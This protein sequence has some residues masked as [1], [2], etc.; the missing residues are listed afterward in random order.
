MIIIQLLKKQGVNHSALLTNVLLLLAVSFVFFA[1]G[2]LTSDVIFDPI[3]TT[4]QHIT[5]YSI[6]AG[7]G[8][9]PIDQYVTSVQLRN[10]LRNHVQQLNALTNTGFSSSDGTTTQTLSFSKFINGVETINSQFITDYVYSVADSFE[11]ILTL[12]KPTGTITPSD[13]FFEYEL[14]FNNGLTTLVDQDGVLTDLI[15]TT[16]SI[17]AQDYVIIAA[18]SAVSGTT[19]SISMDLL[20]PDLQETLSLGDTG[21]YLSNNKDYEVTITNVVLNP[22][23]KVTFGVSGGDFNDVTFTLNEGETTF[24]SNNVPFVLNTVES[25]STPPPST[26]SGLASTTPLGESHSLALEDGII[27]FVD[28]TNNAIRVLNSSAQMIYTL[29]GDPNSPPDY[30]DSTG[31]FALFNNPR[32]IVQSLAEPDLFYVADTGNHVIRQLNVSGS[33]HS[34]NPTAIVTTIA[35]T[36]TLGDSVGDGSTDMD[37]LTAAFNSPEDLYIQQ[38]SS[39]LIDSLYVFDN[40]NTKLKKV[41][42]QGGLNNGLWKVNPLPGRTADTSLDCGEDAPNHYIGNDHQYAVDHFAMSNTTAGLRDLTT[43]Y[44]YFADTGNNMIRAYGKHCNDIG[45]ACIGLVSGLQLIEVAGNCVPGYIDGADGNAAFNAPQGITL[46]NNG[47]LYVADTNNHV[48]RKI[49]P[50]FS[51]SPSLELIG[52]VVTTIAG[53]GTPGYMDGSSTVAQFSSPTTIAFDASTNSLYVYDTGNFKLRQI[54]LN[55]GVVTTVAGGSS[56]VGDI[57]F[58]LGG[59]HLQLNDGDVQ[60]GPLSNDYGF[61]PSGLQIDGLVLDT[62]FVHINATPEVVVGSTTTPFTL[63]SLAYRIVPDTPLILSPQMSLPE[64]L[65]TPKILPGSFNMTYDGTKQTRTPFSIDAVGYDTYTLTFTDAADVTYTVPYL[66]TVGGLHFGSG[67]DSL[68]F[69]EGLIDAPPAIDGSGNPVQPPDLYVIGAGDSFILNGDANDLLDGD[70]IGSVHR[71]DSYDPLTNQVTFTTLVSGAPKTTVVA[72][73]PST[74]PGVLAEGLFIYNGYSHIVYV[75]TISG[76]TGTIVPPL[77]IDL[78]AD[79]VVAGETS[80]TVKGGG[81][82]DLGNGYESLGGVWTSATSDWDNTLMTLTSSTLPF[83]LTTPYEAFGHNSTLQATLPDC[84]LDDPAIV[85]SAFDFTETEASLTLINNKAYLAYVQVY[86]DGCTPVEETLTNLQLG[87]TTTFDFI[88]CTDQ[89]TAGVTI[90]KSF[91]LSYQTGSGSNPTIVSILGDVIAPVIGPFPVCAEELTTFTLDETAGVLDFSSTVSSTCGLQPLGIGGSPAGVTDYGATFLYGSSSTDST[92]VT[93]DYPD[94]QIKPTLAFF[95]DEQTSTCDT[96]FDC[97]AAGL[98]C[99][100]VIDSCGNTVNCGTCTL[101]GESCGAGGTPNVCA[102]GT[103]TPLTDAVACL[104]MACG[105]ATDGCGGLVVCGTCAPGK[106]C[107]SSFMCVD[108]TTI[109]TP[110]TCTDLG[111]NCG[112]VDDGCGTT[113]NCGTCTVAGESC[114]AGGTANICA[115]GTCTPFNVTN[116]CDDVNLNCGNVTDG[117][118]AL[119]DCGTCALGQTCTDNVCT[120][121]GTCTPSTCAD[122]NAVCGG[123]GDGC[124]TT[125]NCGACSGNATCSSNQCVGGTSCSV[126]SDCA[127]SNVCTSGVCVPLNTTVTEFEFDIDDGDADKFTMEEDDMLVIKGLA[128]EY[129]IRLDRIFS[130]DKLRFKSTDADFSSFS[131]EEE[132]DL[133][134]LDLNGNDDYDINIKSLKVDQDDEDAKIEVDVGEGDDSDNSDD[135]DSGN[136]NN[137]NNNQ[138]QSVCGDGVC[139]S[140]ES[141]FACPTDCGTTTTT[142]TTSSSTGVGSGSGSTG[143]SSNTGSSGGY[144]GATVITEEK[145]IS[146]WI[147]VGLIT[148]VVALIAILLMTQFGKKGKQQNIPVT[149]PKK[150]MSKFGPP[151]W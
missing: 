48:I 143:S 84:S 55:D 75:A 140:T 133:I 121:T 72:L 53:V 30:E 15:G 60:D 88:D 90:Q 6:N 20:Y 110:N 148:A 78:N 41:E 145:G 96:P 142:T 150:T 8:S 127:G 69:L 111:L 18:T 132:G 13:A 50:T 22:L 83:T 49:V 135:D 109:C 118:S 9:A 129:H 21:N 40:G 54:S 74:L 100:T 122:L 36:G 114:G 65:S 87:D 28:T 70:E 105:N 86:I 12:K 77:A 62:S 32:G 52:G 3:H 115:P 91:T 34:S 58:Y 64:V 101:T 81:V 61:T 141:V 97:S 59:T 31:N 5:G 45:S 99:G 131:I 25:N 139:G 125:L 46:D 147:W 93:V 42:N 17:G 11:D 57:D 47:N 149:Q 38:G 82:L 134:N 107:D 19:T 51:P 108:D 126:D 89:E 116:A 23:P 144:G 10:P 120:G 26:I 136:N 37:A 104:G 29:A 24:L 112:T 138:Q 94:S 33:L 2:P 98:N 106:M 130:S 95:T 85:C 113:L 117:C 35:G 124:G 103:C 44:E 39:S 63:H 119:I 66:T 79:G 7:S 137:N 71:Y 73:G 4:G 80:L 146:I 1:D 67:S 102:P 123:I 151:S 76:T 14:L 92:S 128:N 68:V 27:I 56:N 43:S 16:V